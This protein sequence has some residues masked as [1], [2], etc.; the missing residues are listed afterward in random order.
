MKKRNLLVMFVAMLLALAMM[1]IIS[2]AGTK[3]NN[4]ET[5]YLIRYNTSLVVLK[6]T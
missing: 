1:P 6:T 4:L 5:L 2:Y 3:L